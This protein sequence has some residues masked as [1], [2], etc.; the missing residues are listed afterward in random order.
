MPIKLLKN[1]ID[2]ELSYHNFDFIYSIEQG[3]SI[4]N[5]KS[6]G[7]LCK[8]DSFFLSKDLDN[9]KKSGTLINNHLDNILP[10][11]FIGKKYLN[12]LNKQED[13]EYLYEQLIELNKKCT[14]IN[15]KIN[16]NN[17]KFNEL[18][19]NSNNNEYDSNQWVMY[20]NQKLPL[21]PKEI[22]KLFCNC[23]NGIQSLAHEQS[24]L[25][26]DFL[27]LKRKIIPKENIN[28]MDLID[29]ESD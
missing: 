5:Q 17:G 19:K 7:D 18:D 9:L 14:K 23:F 11:N 8:R 24:K 13:S 26:N 2:L 6:A 4:T 28:N 29:Q 22:D 21:N 20:G 15:E 16:E 10:N 12:L 25:Q 27:K 3:K 1:T